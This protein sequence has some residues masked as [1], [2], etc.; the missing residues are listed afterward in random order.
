[1]D[2]EVW[3]RHSGGQELVE[4]LVEQHLAVVEVEVGKELAFFKDVVGNRDGGEE[5]GLKDLLLLLVAREQKEKL[6]LEGC[7][8]LAIVEGLQEWILRP[9]LER[10]RGIEPLRQ[11]LHERALSN[12]D[13]TVD[14]D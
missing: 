3:P 1:I 6:G 8:R 13:R 12:A 14:R 2:H 7:R 11:P 10:R 4:L 5:L 9:V